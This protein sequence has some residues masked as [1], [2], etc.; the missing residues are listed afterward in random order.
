[1]DCKEL[2]E[3]IS[4]HPKMSDR[5][6]GEQC[7]YSKSAVQWHRQQ[8]GI[9]RIKA[10]G[11]DETGNRYGRLTVLYKDSTNTRQ[12]GTYWVCQCDCG[13]LTTVKGSNLRNKQKPVRSCGCDRF[14]IANA[15]KGQY[16]LW[17]NG[18][19]KRI[20]E[21]HIQHNVC[22][23]I[24][25]KGKR[26]RSYMGTCPTC[27]EQER[28][29]LKMRKCRD[30]GCTILEPRARLCSMC[31]AKHEAEQ[32]ARHRRKQYARKERTRYANA[33]KN[34]E[35]DWSISLDKLRV[36]DR[37]ICALCG[38]PVDMKAYHVTEEGHFV[39][40]GKYPSIDHII[41]LSKGG[42]HTWNNVQLAHCSCNSIKCDVIDG[43]GA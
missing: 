23:H 31:R 36:R 42:T 26:T 8:L 15:R 10:Q 33:R 5:E 28:Q 40:H 20:D 25:P 1:M 37:N 16:E 4:Q 41:P 19:W 35:I 22:G 29:A 43:E 9:W 17:D 7:G 12:D 3:F 13:N 34:G 11:I 18:T 14:N 2:K 24:I 6:V 32:K 21:S 27:V 38:K 39:A 30:C